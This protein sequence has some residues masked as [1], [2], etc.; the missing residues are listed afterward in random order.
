MGKNAETGI[1]FSSLVMESPT[2]AGKSTLHTTTY[3][4][5]SL[6]NR[7]D[8][9]CWSNLVKQCEIYIKIVLHLSVKQ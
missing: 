3:Q 6:W 1:L 5:I 8:N 9:I 2:A 4:F 7:K